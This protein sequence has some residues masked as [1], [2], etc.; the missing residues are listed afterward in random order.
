MR[1]LLLLLLAACADGGAGTSIGNPNMTLLR[2][3]PSGVELSSATLTV[4]EITLVGADG[5][6]EGNR[7]GGDD[8]LNGVELEM[9][10]GVWTSVRLTMSGEFVIL[11]T[12]G[13]DTIDLQLSVPEVS[14]EVSRLPI[15]LDEPHVFELAYPDWLTAAEAGWSAG[16][17]HVVRP[18]DALHDPL[19]TKVAQR[20]S[21]LPDADEDGQPE[22]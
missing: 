22:R 14:V 11:G 7:I 19:A 9:P 6:A 1:P 5:E 4:D 10:K 13:A 16:E 18:G 17:A 8:V 2:I 20:S 12:D 21:L 3:A 15:E